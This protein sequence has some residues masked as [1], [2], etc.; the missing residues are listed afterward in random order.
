MN[1][2]IPKWAEND[3]V[4]TSKW[5]SIGV[6]LNDSQDKQLRVNLKQT[7]RRCYLMESSNFCTVHV[8]TLCCSAAE[9][10]WLGWPLPLD[11]DCPV[12]FRRVMEEVCPHLNETFGRRLDS[13]VRDLRYQGGRLLFEILAEEVNTIMLTY[14]IFNNVAGKI[15]TTKMAHFAQ[16]YYDYKNIQDYL[17]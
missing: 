12:V 16:F 2:K 14:K 3:G 7:T 15:P 6:I 9:V 10:F 5:A 1:F 8:L 4:N 17:S 13:V 11:L